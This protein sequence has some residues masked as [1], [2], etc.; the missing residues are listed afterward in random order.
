MSVATAPLA[1]QD[2]I[3]ATL[4]AHFGDGVF[5]ISRFRGNLR[6]FVSKERLTELLTALKERCGCNF[7]VEL[8]GA[9]YLGYPGRTRHR[10]EVHYVV[11]NLDTGG[12][13]IVKA[14]DK[15]IAKGKKVATGKVNSKG[16]VKLVLKTKLPKGTSTLKAQLLSSGNVKGSTD[17]VKVKVI[18]K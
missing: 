4:A 14:V 9:D 18:K 17:S 11:R 6:L 10:F 3:L 13:A 5:S 2:R 8:G 15:V 16:K 1:A 12:T 7:L